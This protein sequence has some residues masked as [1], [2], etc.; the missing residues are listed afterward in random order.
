MPHPLLPS[1]FLAI[2]ALSTEALS[3]QQ[4]L[5]AV[6]GDVQATFYFLFSHPGFVQRVDAATGSLDRRKT[7]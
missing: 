2:L 5:F 4:V 3:A 7:Q 6:G 1:T